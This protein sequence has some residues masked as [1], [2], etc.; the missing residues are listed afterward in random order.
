ME[1]SDLTY[2][3]L[4][5]RVA[6]LEE[7]LQ[8]IHSEQQRRKRIAG[9]SFSVLTKAILRLFLGS[10]LYKNTQQLWDAWREWFSGNRTNNWPEFETRDFVASLLSRFI[11]IGVVGLVAVLL[12][13]VLLL[14]QTTL[15]YQQNKLIQAQ[16]QLGEAS[17]RSTL[18]AEL[19]SILDH[20]DLEIGKQEE[21][22]SSKKNK[23]GQ[24]DPRPTS[25]DGVNSERWVLSNRLAG[26]IIALSRS[27][28]PYRNLDYVYS[29]S[30]H[31]GHFESYY[32]DVLRAW[33]L[34]PERGQLLISLLESRVEMKDMMRGADFSYAD[35]R[36]TS[37]IFTDLS[38][39][40]LT[41]AHFSG[42]LLRGTSL[43][44]ANLKEGNL[45]E[46]NLD[47]TNFTNADLRHASFV[48]AYLETAEL[49][50]ARVDMGWLDKYKKELGD[51][52]DYWVIKEEPTGLVLRAKPR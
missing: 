18:I 45:S 43:S 21:L 50:G 47:R 17:R 12:P 26:R 2:D 48:R 1:E 31:N 19:T 20:V 9:K 28:R 29:W 5:A 10:A 46:T 7:Q 32:E 51:R 3:E 34:S 27:L 41:G 6:N 39:A 40:K 11:R 22:S 52:S 15:L 37:I 33:P 38:G 16:N 23:E 44:W 14:I 35:L 24:A 4:K 8:Q 36:D 42:S 30:Y 25:D 13:F 49:E